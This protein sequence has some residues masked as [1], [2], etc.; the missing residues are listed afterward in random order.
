MKVLSLFFCVIM[1]VFM[2]SFNIYAVEPEGSVRG[3]YEGSA[4]PSQTKGNRE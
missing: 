4:I 1:M 2:F 3:N